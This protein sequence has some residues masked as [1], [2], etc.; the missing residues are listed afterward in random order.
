[1]TSADVTPPTTGEP[2]AAGD[3]AD[4]AGGRGRWRRWREPVAWGLLV[5][6][7]ALA[8]ISTVQWQRL[9]AAEQERGAARETAT[10]FMATLTTWDAT[11]GM[12]GVR[13]SLRDASTE[14]FADEIDQLFGTTEDLA[15]LSE[16]SARSEGEILRAHL[17]SVDG[18]DAVALV[19]AEQR[20]VAERAAR[21]E[22]STRY[23]ELDLE[24]TD[25][26]W[27]VDDV[28]LLVDTSDA[29]AGS[30]PSGDAGSDT[31][32]TEEGP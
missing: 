29:R 10:E 15:G 20:L 19:V 1:M 9:A 26:A 13:E 8:T 24:R 27:L 16:L 11:E 6:A 17:Q 3:A 31:P 7:L 22:T 12:G 32:E 23:A 18:D 4:A 14:R 2:G 21:E 28:E 25:G 5:A 30:L